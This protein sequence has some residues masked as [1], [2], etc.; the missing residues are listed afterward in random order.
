MA[1]LRM[2]NKRR[3]HDKNVISLPSGEASTT[4]TWTAELEVKYPGKKTQEECRMFFHLQTSL[5]QNKNPPGSVRAQLSSQGREGE[6]CGTTGW[7]Q[8]PRA[9][10]PLPSGWGG[11][12]ASGSSRAFAYRFRSSFSRDIELLWSQL[13][14]PVCSHSCFSL[15][16]QRARVFH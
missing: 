1:N 5:D 14:F 6:T 10:A 15:F 3:L 13:F 8:L 12:L 7:W 11:G 9:G 2:V 4:A 16:S